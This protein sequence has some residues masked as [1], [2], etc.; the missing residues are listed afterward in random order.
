MQVLTRTWLALKHQFSC[1]RM[2]KKR[3]S[4]FILW[5]S[6]LSA[7]LKSHLIWYICSEMITNL[8]VYAANFKLKVK[9]G[10]M[11]CVSCL[12]ALDSNLITW[13]N[14]LL[15][16]IFNRRHC[17]SWLSLNVAQPTYLSSPPPPTNHQHF[18][19][20]NFHQIFLLHNFCWVY[21]SPVSQYFILNKQWVLVSETY[22]EW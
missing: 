18:S 16:C 8:S 22:S 10:G 9:T 6:V 3:N 14:W 2:T 15:F 4:K 5:H 21:K 12:K 20:F 13:R 11:F 7:L 19:P 17:G 1:I